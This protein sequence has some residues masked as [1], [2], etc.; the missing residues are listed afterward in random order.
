MAWHANSG[1]LWLRYVYRYK[2]PNE[3]EELVYSE[4]GSLNQKYVATLDAHGN[5]I[6]KSAF[7]TKTGAVDNKYAYTYEFD[8]HG[9][10]IKQTTS[11]WGMKDGRSQFL[12]Y[13]ITYRTIT[14]Y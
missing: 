11:K 4:N 6:E 3:R 2:N 14:Y 12:P 5:E 7:N 10:W 9:N 8:R 1:N 13:Y